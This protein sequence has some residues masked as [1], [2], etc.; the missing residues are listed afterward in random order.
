MIG[1]RVSAAIG[2]SALACLAVAGV[3]SA[4][5]ANAPRPLSQVSSSSLTPT[6][7][8][9]TQVAG[10]HA[11]N[12]AELAAEISSGGTKWLDAFGVRDIQAVEVDQ[13]TGAIR[14]LTSEKVGSRAVDFPGTSVVATVDGGATVVF[15]A[16]QNDGSAS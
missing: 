6:D 7:L 12:T 5:V 2:G 1:L 15:Q 3:A 10:L 4:S 8:S 16:G 13:V 9:S 11:G 14:V